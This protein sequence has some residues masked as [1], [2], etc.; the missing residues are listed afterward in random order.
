MKIQQIISVREG[1]MDGFRKARG[2]GAAPGPSAAAPKPSAPAPKAAQ[3]AASPFS[4][5]SNRDAKLILT[6]VINGQALDSSQIAKLKAVLR[7]L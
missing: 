7:K 2:A 5:I 1:F 3:P 4:I 6:A